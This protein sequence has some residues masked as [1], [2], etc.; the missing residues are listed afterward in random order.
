VQDTIAMMQQELDAILDEG[1]A[2]FTGAMHGHHGDHPLTFIKK[3]A[4]YQS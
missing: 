2:L 1:F 3:Q 4:T